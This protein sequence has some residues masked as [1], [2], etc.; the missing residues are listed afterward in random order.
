MSCE[1]ITAKLATVANTQPY[2]P[3]NTAFVDTVRGLPRLRP[4]QCQRV[5]AGQELTRTDGEALTILVQKHPGE[6]APKKSARDAI[7][8]KLL[9]RSGAD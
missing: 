5:F 3:F 6:S 4:Q 7:V 9:S 8:E 1:Q 2:D